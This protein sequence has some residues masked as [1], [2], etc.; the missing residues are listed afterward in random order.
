MKGFKKLKGRSKMAK[1]EGMEVVGSGRGLRCASLGKLLK[2]QI[3]LSE[4]T[5]TRSEADR[6]GTVVTE[7]VVSRDL[8][9]GGS[10]D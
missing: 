1:E 6:V 2:L 3:I 4:V 9:R 5:P 8:R 7:H 10:V